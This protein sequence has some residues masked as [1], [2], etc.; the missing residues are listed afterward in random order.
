MKQWFKQ[1][2][3]IPKSLFYS[4]RLMGVQSVVRL[5]IRIA[6]DTHVKGLTKETFDTSAV[7]K[8]SIG[9][10]GSE[11]VTSKG[12]SALLVGPGGKIIPKGK[13]SLAA[14][15]VIRVD[16]GATLIIGDGFASN[17]NTEIF[18]S[19]QI[20]IGESCLF[21][22][23]VAVRDSDGHR[24]RTESGE[25]LVDRKDVSIGNHVWVAANVDILKGSRIGD[26]CVVGYRSCVLGVLD[27][28][29]AIIGGYPAKILRKNIVWEQ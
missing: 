16:E 25:Y 3:S 19:K 13:I 1:L 9:F 5:P 26:N 23:N 12:G 11:G 10:G 29:N 8:F 27:C 17:K 2:L 14:G 28:S 6:Y 21:G 18:C 22:W 15:S 7:V 24:I 20:T 4:I